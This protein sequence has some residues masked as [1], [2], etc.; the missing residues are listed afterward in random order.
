MYSDEAIS[1]VYGLLKSTPEGGLRKMLMSG[2]LTEVH[3]RLLMKIA[4]GC[5]E[6]DFITSFKE[7]K[8]PTMRY[9]PAESKIKEHF[10]KIC[11][12]K[13]SSLG[14]LSLGAKAA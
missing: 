6:A 10:W 4:K 7:E 14:L 11:K 8:L 9:S 12:N 2:E 1:G 13:F 5:S 3:F